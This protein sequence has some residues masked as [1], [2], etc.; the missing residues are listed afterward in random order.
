MYGADEGN[1][2]VGNFRSFLN[3]NVQGFNG[4]IASGVGSVMCSYSGINWLP[5]ALSPFL[6]NTLRKELNFD[7]FI[8]SDYDQLTRIKEQKLPTS[9]QT[10]DDSNQTTSSVL[11]AGIDMVMI[12]DKSD[13]LDYIDA[14]KF[15][16]ENKT[17][18]TA[19]LNDA[20]ARILSVKMALGLVKGS[21]ENIR[22]EPPAEVPSSS[23]EYEDSLQAV[24]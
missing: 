19:R 6:L 12:P 5:M 2:H 16:I 1:A 23:T 17:L 3:H 7:G 8:I 21:S 15:S 10:M 24:H 20:V 14:V 11:N 9:F 13:Y 22:E 18:S 4:S